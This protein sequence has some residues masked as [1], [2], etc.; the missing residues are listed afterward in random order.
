MNTVTVNKADLIQTVTENREKHR[1][2]FL[3]AQ[4]VYRERMIAE[5]DRALQEAR[6]GGNIRRAFTLPVPEDHTDD[7]DNALAMLEWEVGDTVALDEYTF[8]SLV[9]NQWGWNASFAAS[10]QQYVREPQ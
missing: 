7:F 4:D 9:R 2:L 8:S 3:R 10:T 1:E 6:E 5:L